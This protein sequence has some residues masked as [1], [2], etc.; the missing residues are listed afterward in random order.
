MSMGELRRLRQN[1]IQKIF[2]KVNHHAA[3]EGHEPL[4]ALA[5]IVGFQGKADLYNAKAQQ[6]GPD[7]LDGAEHK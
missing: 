1:H 3:E 5:C 4:G 7:G 6:D 2:R